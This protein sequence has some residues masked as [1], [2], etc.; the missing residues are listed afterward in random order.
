LPLT[1]KQNRRFDY[2]F[3]EDLMP[4]LDYFITTTGRHQAYNVTPDES[5]ELLE[6]ARR[7]CLISGKKLPVVFAQEGMGTE[8]SGDNSRLRKEM[9]GLNF[10]GINCAIE[11]LYANYLDN[12]EWVNREVLL[13]DR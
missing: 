4:V 7:V 6:I 13:S 9:P 1:I 11:K 3:V 10:T 5:V 12:K 8:Y 2:L